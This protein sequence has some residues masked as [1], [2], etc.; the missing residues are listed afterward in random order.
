MKREQIRDYKAGQQ[1]T[2]GRINQLVRAAR[3]DVTGQPPIVVQSVGNT[4]QIV[5]TPHKWDWF[6]ARIQAKS[7]DFSDQQYW[8]RP[9]RVS[10]SDGDYSDVLTWEDA[11]TVPS[12]LDV[13]AVNLAESDTH[14]LPTDGVVIVFRQEDDS[15]PTN[16][17][18]FMSR[19]QS[20]NIQFAKVLA[21]TWD[22]GTEFV[23]SVT[24][25]PCNA[26]GGEINDTIELTL[27]ATDDAIPALKNGLN[28]KIGF[29]DIE[30][31]DIVGYL[32]SPAGDGW[33]GTIVVHAGLNGAILT[34][35]T[36][37]ADEISDAAT[38]MSDAVTSIVGGPGI[39]VD[40]TD[41]QV[42][43]VSADVTSNKGLIFSAP[44]NDGTLEIKPNANKAIEATVNG[45][46]VVVNPNHG[47]GVDSDGLFFWPEGGDLV[48]SKPDNADGWITYDL[49][50]RAAHGDPQT[51]ILDTASDL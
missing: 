32:P 7:S 18:H 30:E 12:D 42:P 16:Y 48:Y 1:I 25:N 43:I 5:H 46:G 31:N 34:G 17:R 38:W 13:V 28:L 22:A 21:L 50:G 6:P 40:N 3:R 35:P 15:S 27:K 39:A 26:A 51:Y 10:N 20:T 24:A 14:R 44:G 41:P 19:V 45:I 47:L 11:G 23:K 4:W 8:I 36:A 33:D 9:V 49:T 2:T 29:S 37:L